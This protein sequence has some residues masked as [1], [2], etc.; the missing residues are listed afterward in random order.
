VRPSGGT[1]ADQDQVGTPEG[2]IKS[3]VEIS[4]KFQEIIFYING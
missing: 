4:K 3:F 2:W 1:P